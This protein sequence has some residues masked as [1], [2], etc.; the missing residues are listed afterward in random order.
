MKLGQLLP[1]PACTP[2][3]GAIKVFGNSVCKTCKKDTAMGNNSKIKDL[4]KFEGV[5]AE[6]AD[7][8]HTICEEDNEWLSQFGGEWVEGA[9][10]GFINIRVSDWRGA[11]TL[12][13][14]PK[15]V[16]R[17]YAEE[18]CNISSGC[19]TLAGHTSDWRQIDELAKFCLEWFK[20]VNCKGLEREAKSF[21]LKLRK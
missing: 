1:Y 15:E 3:C 13:V 14:T 6:P 17:Y 9:A 2:H 4:G 5:S 11:E 16:A 19:R 18:A 10:K 7:D 20:R 8:P 12:T 21:G